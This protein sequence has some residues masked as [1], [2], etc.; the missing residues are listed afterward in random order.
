MEIHVTVNE[1]PLTLAAEPAETI[2]R[3][4][5]REGFY[6]VKHGCED[7]TCGVCAVILDGRL[8]NSCILLAAQADGKRITTIEALGARERMHPLQ[9]A[10]VEAGAVQC[11]YCTPARILAAKALLDENAHPTE[12]DV[13]DALS[14]VLCRCTGYVKPV[15]AVMRVVNGKGETRNV[16]PI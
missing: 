13:R 3:V 9:A 16:P 7:G 14:G 11:G 5:R 10:F 8:V 6:G 15:E 12:A 2:L 4:L 1:V